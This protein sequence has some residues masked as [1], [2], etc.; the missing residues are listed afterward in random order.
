MAGAGAAKGALSAASSIGQKAGSGKGGG[1]SGGGISP[2]QAALAQY[3]MGQQELKIA[4]N[5][6]SSGL[7]ASTMKTYEQAGPQFGAAMEMAGQSDANAASLQQ[8]AQAAQNQNTSNNAFGSGF[9]ST[10][11]F[12]STQGGF[13]T[14]PGTGTDASGGEAIA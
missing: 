3:T 14:N 4:S 13:S 9:N 2:Q 8:L 6:A 1:G 12:G 5:A 11:N 10:G 7:G